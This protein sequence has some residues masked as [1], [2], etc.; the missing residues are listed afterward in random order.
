[1]DRLPEGVSATVVRMECKQELI[2]RLHSF[3]LVPG[4]VVMIRY[5][6]P[7]GK[8]AAFECR[9]AVLALRSKDMKGVYVEW[10]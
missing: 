7:G 10:G 5:R 1:M 8:A 6:S 9:G 4:T 2:H 3:G